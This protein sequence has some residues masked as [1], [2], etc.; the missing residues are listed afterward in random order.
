[1]ESAAK[2]KAA[3]GAA[4][5]NESRPSKRQKV[6]DDPEQAPETVE[7]TQEKGLKFLESL[8]AAKDKT[9]RLLPSAVTDRACSGRPIAVHFL[10]LPDKDEIPEYYEVIKLPIAIDTIENKLNR[11]EYSSLALVESDCKRLVNNAKSF[12]DKKSIIYED[13]ERLRKT[14]SNWMVKHNP[15]YRTPGYQAVA[16]PVPG[17]EATPPGRPIPRAAV[18]TPR[19]VATPSPTTELADRPRRAA[20]AAQPNTP[21]PSKLRQSASAAPTQASDAPGFEGKTFQQAQDQ[22]IRELI[23]YVEPESDLQI[24]Q[25][26]VNL[27]SRSLKDYYQLIKQPTSLSGVQKKVRGVVGRNPPTGVSEYKSWSAFEDD[28]TLIWKNARIYNEDGSDIY[29]VS[30]DLEEIFKERLAAAKAHVEEPPQPKLKLNMSTGTPAATPASAPKQ[31][32]K[33]KLRQSPGSDPNTPRARNSATPGVIVDN[34]AL[35]RQQ[36]HVLESMNGQRSSRPS[37]SGK[38]GTPGAAANPFSGPR[39]G[40][41]TVAPAAGQTATAGSPA[42][43]N[44]IKNDVQS[45]ALNAI[46]PVSNASDGQSQRLSVPAQTPAMAPPS[47]VSRT[48]SGSPHPNGALG[49][50]PNAATP[51]QIPYY[52]PPVTPQVDNFRKTP[53]KSIDEALIPK[54][55]LSTHPALNLA[56]PWSTTITAN[57]EKTAHSITMNLPP[58]H[59]YLQIVPQVPIA[60]TGRMYRLFVIVNTNKAYEVNRIPVTAGINGSGGMGAGYEGGKKKG[61]PVYEAKLVAGVNRIEV[62]I[63]AEKDRKGKPETKEAKDQV[64]IEKCTIFLHLMRSC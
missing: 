16:T 19:T 52:V 47:V 24:F 60:L 44:G 15:A 27:P 31:Q 46:R 22:I 23:E 20:A 53:L 57:K 5:E 50:P 18:S 43:V 12:N 37:S 28:V 34:E 56:K 35:L 41:A 10:T 61:E 25:P 8:K 4:P 3:A 9:D 36:R 39:A 11:G 17:E 64:E 59:S 13:A 29:N 63:I 1:M 32:L 14:A 48:N 45:P 49:Q 33:L 6:P 40:S 42:P 54:I 55:A 38:A 2:R 7:T 62:E 21:V 51:Y 30:L 58:T 26:F